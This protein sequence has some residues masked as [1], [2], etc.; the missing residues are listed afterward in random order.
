MKLVLP[1]EFYRQGGVERVICGTVEEWIK[2]DE[3]EEIILILSKKN[4]P[5]FQEKLPS[6]PIIKYESFT[7]PPKSLQSRILSLINKL[8]FL[9]SNL[10]AEKVEKFFK[11]LHRKCRSDF[12]IKYLVNRYQATHCLYFLT[13]RLN[14]P[15]LDI[16]LAMVS[17]DVFWRFAPLTYPESYVKEYL[18]LIHI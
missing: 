8:L 14:P 3:V 7:L 5:H 16:P 12:S 17:H 18:S 1:I 6:S 10:K 9:S 13:N 2:L 11:G 15:N 4:I